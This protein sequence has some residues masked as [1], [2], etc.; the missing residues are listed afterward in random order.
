MLYYNIYNYNKNKSNKKEQ[1][2]P[3]WFNK[4]LGEGGFIDDDEDF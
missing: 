1:D 2:I 4:D 3:K